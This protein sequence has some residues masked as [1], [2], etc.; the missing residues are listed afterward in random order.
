[1]IMIT[2]KGIDKDPDL[3]TKIDRAIFPGL[4]GG[5]HNHTTAAIAVALKEASL[6]EFTAY[7]QQIVKNTKALENEFRAAGI[8]MVADG[9]DNHLLLLD[10]SE[11]GSLGAQLEFALDIAHI[12]TNK[13][14]I[15]CEPCS[16]YF[17]SGL[18][19]GTPA[20]TTRGFKEN[21]MKYVAGWIVKVINHIKAEKM[22]S[23]KEERPKFMKAFKE[24]YRN[25][26]YLLQIGEEI[27]QYTKKFP[28]PGIE[29]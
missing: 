19:L 10:L 13:N 14:T 18:R 27:K 3:A 7:V 2:Q 12:T 21:D 22:P 23:T 9:S 6:P 29:V 5:P 17:P 20:L 16:P 24:K 11:N 28:I 25:D 8:K 1:M 4:Q 15:P 26:T